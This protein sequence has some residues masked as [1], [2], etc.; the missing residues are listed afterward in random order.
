MTF[1]AWNDRLSVDI[2]SMD[3]EHKEL[4]AI[5][6]DL[7][8]DIDSG[9]ARN[10]ISETLNRLTRYTEHHFLHEEQLFTR[11]TYPD[12]EMHKRQ[13]AAMVG[14]LEDC[15]DRYD[16]GR[17]SGLSLEIVNYLKDWLF[18]HILGSD[19]NYIQHL[20]AAGIS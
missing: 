19:R 5:L 7:Y 11:S 4:I 3:S 18:D 1:I 9:A 20:H 6:N 16:S 13:H 2:A 10:A 8:R 15:H 12:A 17:L 14:W